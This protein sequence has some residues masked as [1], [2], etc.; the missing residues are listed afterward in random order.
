MGVQEKEGNYFTLVSFVPFEFCTMCMYY[1][2]K[3][4]S[5]EKIETKKCPQSQRE[6]VEVRWYTKLSKYQ[7][8]A[9]LGFPPPLFTWLRHLGCQKGP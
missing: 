9:V 6:H 1:K 5:T 8:R 3:N 2:F 7:K 4:K